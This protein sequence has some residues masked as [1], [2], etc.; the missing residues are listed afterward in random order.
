MGPKRLLV[1]GSL[2]AYIFLI[3]TNFAWMVK[4]KSV[5]AEIFVIWTNVARTKVAWTIVTVKVGNG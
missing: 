2:A 3:W 5:T 4:I 1:I